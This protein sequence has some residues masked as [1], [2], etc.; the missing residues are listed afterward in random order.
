MAGLRGRADKEIEAIGADERR[1]NR[2][3]Q[4]ALTE[5]RIGSNDVVENDDSVIRAVVAKHPPH[6]LD[7]LGAVGE[8]APPGLAV[9]VSRSEVGD[10]DDE[11][12]RNVGVRH[13][14]RLVRFSGVICLRDHDHPYGWTD[15]AAISLWLHYCVI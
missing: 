10:G 4:P 8:G 7:P 12:Q 15:R 2:M 13:W 11:N 9:G 5:T 6:A 3:Q 1:F 14:E